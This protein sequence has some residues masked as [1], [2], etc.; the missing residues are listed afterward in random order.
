MEVDLRRCGQ[1]DDE[2]ANAEEL[3]QHLETIH[4]AYVSENEEENNVTAAGCG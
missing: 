4:G 3:S 1:C 2:F